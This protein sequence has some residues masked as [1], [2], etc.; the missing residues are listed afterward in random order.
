MTFPTDVDTKCWKSYRQTKYTAFS[1]LL[2]WFLVTFI[3]RMI[4][5]CFGIRNVIK[6]TFYFRQPPVSLR[7]HRLHHF[8]HI[9]RDIVDFV[10]QNF[11]QDPNTRYLVNG[12]GN[13]RFVA[14][15][16]LIKKSSSN[17][18]FQHRIAI[19]HSCLMEKKIKMVIMK[20]STEI[21]TLAWCF[22]EQGL[23]NRRI[24]SIKLFKLKKSE[25]SF[26]DL[27][28]HKKPDIVESN[29]IR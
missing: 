13:G 5:G 10:P 28:C 26:F 14:C 8:Y 3:G 25:L 7:R 1:L 6:K 19:Y 29:L 9:L 18:S 24:N 16:K 11:I 12:S 21:Q 27:K 15:F 4:F 23:V 22:A 2:V 17:L 20:I